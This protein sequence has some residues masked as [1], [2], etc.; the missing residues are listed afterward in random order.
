[1]KAL[2]EDARKRAAGLG[3]EPEILATKRDLVALAAGRPPAHLRDGWR[4]VAL[5]LDCRD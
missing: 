1:M 2:Q 4:A 3:L 5:G